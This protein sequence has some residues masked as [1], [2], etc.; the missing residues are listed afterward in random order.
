MG[1]IG[2]GVDVLE[3]ERL[4]AALERTPTLLARLFTEAEQALCTTGSG[5]LRHGSLA[6]R[7]AAK[8]AVAK[9]LGSGIDGFSFRDVEV[10]RDEAGRP[11]VT[12]HGGARERAQALG[13][14]HVH[15]SVSTGRGIAVANAIAEG[16]LARDVGVGA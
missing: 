13:V 9:A 12:L 5:A 11:V 16:V 2:I 14:E 15:V 1:V 6:G 7:F 4:E 3:I 10:L 8:E